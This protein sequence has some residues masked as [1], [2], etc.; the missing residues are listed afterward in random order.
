MTDFTDSVKG[1]S[2]RIL[3]FPTCSAGKTR[4]LITKTANSR[5]RASMGRRGCVWSQ[6][7]C[8]WAIQS[9]LPNRRLYICIWNS[10]K[11]QKSHW[12]KCLLPKVCQRTR[13]MFAIWGRSQQSRLQARGPFQPQLY[14]VQARCL[15]LSS[16]KDDA[17]WSLS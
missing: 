4:M 7:G 15:P 5:N 17:G 2:R 10:E 3:G 16:K 9:D 8:S 13:F 1:A 14:H 6:K 12:F 11:D